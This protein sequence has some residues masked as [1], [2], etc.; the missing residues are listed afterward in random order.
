VI[1]E[2]FSNGNEIKIAVNFQLNLLME[3]Q[4]SLS[5]STETSSDAQRSFK[6]FKR[7]FT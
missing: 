1:L 6:G 2:R 3:Y 4:S 5:I 7:G